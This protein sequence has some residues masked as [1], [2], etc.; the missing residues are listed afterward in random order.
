VALPRTF[1][2]GNAFQQ[3]ILGFPVSRKLTVDLAEREIGLRGLR[4]DLQGAAQRSFGLTP[5]ARLHLLLFQQRLPALRVFLLRFGRR[6]GVNNARRRGRVGF[7]RR[8]AVRRQL[9]DNV[10]AGRSFQVDLLLRLAVTGRAHGDGV[11][12][13]L[14][15]GEAERAVAIGERLTGQSAAITL[16]RRQDAL[17]WRAA[18]GVPHLPMHFGGTHRPLPLRPDER[19]YRDKDDHRAQAKQ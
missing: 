12:R 10:L 3:D 2:Q 4:V 1:V 5:V 14:Q 13:F 11:L 6:V 9:Q 18:H 7:I 17:G 16:H 19:D 8:V 15:S